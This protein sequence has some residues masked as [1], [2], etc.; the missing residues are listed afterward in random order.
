[1]TILSFRHTL[2]ACALL[3]C[4]SLARAQ[5]GKPDSAATAVPTVVAAVEPLPPIPRAQRPQLMVG[6]FEFTATVSNDDLQELNALSTALILLRATDPGA[7][8]R[9]TQDNLGS[10]TADLL[11]AR[12]LQTG[13]FRVV[14]RKALEAVL[15]EQELV[16]SKKAAGGQSVAQKS[17]LLGAK[18]LLTGSIT[19][20]SRSK[21]EKGG[22][23]G[24]ASKVIGGIGLSQSQAT[25]EVGL[26]GRI[27]ETATGGGWPRRSRRRASRWAIRCG[28]SQRSVA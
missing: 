22:I 8:N 5:S 24:L 6:K 27:V 7:R 17:Q 11:V 1:M 3:A 21:Q 14:E 26:A 19:K 10:T 25:F 23:A 13:Q 4:G 20:F 12:L 18:Y 16:G 28:R 15:A 2:A 9:Q